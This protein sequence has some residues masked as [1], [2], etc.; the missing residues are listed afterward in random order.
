MDR[1]IVTPP[2]V[3]EPK[4]HYSHGVVVTT[5]R[6]LYVAGQVPL[7]S[8]GNLV[9]RGDPEAQAVQ[10]LDNLLEVVES[11]GGRIEDIAKTSVFLVNLEHR[12]A[13]GRVRRNFFSDDP[14]ANSL[15]VVRS[16]ASP[17][18]LVEIEAVVPLPE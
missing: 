15:L 7:D 18:F 1:T 2:G 10:V 9:G 16:L 13:V 5:T 6:T 4:G 14:P 8:D 17:E 12:V 3:T 11:A